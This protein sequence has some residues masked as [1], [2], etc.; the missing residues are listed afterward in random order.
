MPPRNRKRT[1]RPKRSSPPRSSSQH[2]SMTRPVNAVDL[3]RL[4]DSLQVGECSGTIKLVQGES[5]EV[6]LTY[7]KKYRRPVRRKP[8]FV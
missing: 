2:A 1:P 8:S 3:T 7:N 6:A 4:V 5:V